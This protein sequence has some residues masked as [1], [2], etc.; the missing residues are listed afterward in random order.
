MT[1]RYG[2]TCALVAKAGVCHQ[3]VEL[4]G[5][6]SAGRG[7]P[8][9]GDSGLDARLRVASELREQPWGP[10]HRVMFRLIDELA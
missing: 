6:F 3:C 7:N 2:T 8:L 4:D 9:A 10:W 1:D 5:F